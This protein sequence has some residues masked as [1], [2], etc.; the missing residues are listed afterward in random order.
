MKKISTIILACCCIGVLIANSNQASAQSLQIVGDTVRNFTAPCT[1]LTEYR[2]KVKNISSTPVKVR[3]HREIIS[4]KDSQQ[5]YFCWVNC[6]TS[7]VDDSPKPGSSEKTPEITAGRDTSLFVAYVEPRFYDPNTEELV[8]NVE[9]LSEVRYHFYNE[10]DMSD[11]ATVLIRINVS[12]ATGVNEGSIYNNTKTSIQPNPAN[13]KVTIS[14]AAPLPFT[15]GTIQ[16][17]DALGK[18]CAEIPVS[19]QYPPFLYSNR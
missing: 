3:V 1:E 6:Y 15:L 11:E 12:C 10:E 9:G 8:A 18:V 4:R 16:L 19:G 7:A 13:E 14:F 2:V 17:F 5:V